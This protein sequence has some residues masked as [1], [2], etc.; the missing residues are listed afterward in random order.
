MMDTNAFK[1]VAI[2]QKPSN[3]IQTLNTKIFQT[4][5]HRQNHMLKANVL[6]KN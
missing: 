5:K 3:L 6:K 4:I 1:D 2:I